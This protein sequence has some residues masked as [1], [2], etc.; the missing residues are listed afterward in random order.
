MV[1]VSFASAHILHITMV[2]QYKEGQP[3]DDYRN[4][5]TDRQYFFSFNPKNKEWA[6]IHDNSIGIIDKWENNTEL[7]KHLVML[8]IGDSCCFLKEF[9]PH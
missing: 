2:S 7:A 4:F 8:S 3:I 6:V 5:T 1:C 9:L